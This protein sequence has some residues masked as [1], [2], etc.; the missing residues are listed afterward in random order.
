M[1]KLPVKENQGHAA[2]R[3][4]MASL[5]VGED[6]GPAY[7]VWE[8]KIALPNNFALY[9]SYGALII[10]VPFVESMLFQLPCRNIFGTKIEYFGI[11]SRA[12]ENLKLAGN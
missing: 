12:S 4:R 11:L 1:A 2:P 6:E 8:D 9:L 10:S 7:L 3:V 5:V